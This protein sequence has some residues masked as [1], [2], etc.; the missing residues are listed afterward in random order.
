MDKIL[1]I[2]IAL[3]ITV[4]ALVEYCKTISDMIT[5]KAFKKAVLQGAAIAVSLIFFFTADINL[6]KAF[7]ITFS[8][9]WIGTATTAIL[10]SRGANFISDFWGKFS[11]KIYIND[12][13]DDEIV[14]KVIGPFH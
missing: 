9:D 1:F 10:A 3:A 11:G 4:E 2:V 5:H 12:A 6:F 7:G 8:A 13:S 14:E